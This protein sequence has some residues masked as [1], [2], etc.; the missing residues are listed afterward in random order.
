MSEREQVEFK[1]YYIA[2]FNVNYLFQGINQSLFAVIIPIYLIQFIGVL[3]A[4]KLAFMGSIISLPWIFKIFYG[5]LGDKFGFKKIGRRRPWIISMVSFS[6]VLWIILGLNNMITA[7]NAI[8]VFTIMGILIFLGVAF[9]DTIIDGLLLDITPKEKL[10]R[11]S[12]LNWGLRSVGAIAG[13]PF[14]ALFVVNGGLDVPSLFIII[15]IIT[16]LCSFLTVLIKEP[17]VYPEAKIGKHLKEMFD[18][19][20]DWKTYGFALFASIVDAVGILFVSIFILIN[21]GLLS[22]SGTSLSLPSGDLNIYLVNGYITMIISIGVVIGAILGGQIADRITRKVSVYIAYII[23][24]I[25]LLLMMVPLEWPIL[26]TFSTLIGC[27]I[28]W[29]HSSYAAV[30]TEISKQHPEMGSTYYSLCNAFANLGGTLGLSL[31]GIILSA[32]ASYLI[33]FLFLAIVSNFGL[34]AFLMLK[35]EDYEHK[36]IK[37]K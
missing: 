33:V 23:T 5:I 4:S 20:R 17:T 32:T 35:K 11:V 25:A 3:D 14:F 6:G 22:S 30:T 34:G 21:M 26:L 12:G 27:A 29:R 16:I 8:S 15:G 24:T 13:G 7:E 18:N 37:E 10:G 1:N 2:I 31:T 28:G 9:G 19:K 36:I